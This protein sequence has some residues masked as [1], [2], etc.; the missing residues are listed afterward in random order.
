M[1]QRTSVSRLVASPTT[2]GKLA[3]PSRPTLSKTSTAAKRVSINPNPVTIPAT[4]DQTPIHTTTTTTST[5]AATTV[6]GTIPVA[7]TADPK[8][9]KNVIVSVASPVATEHSYANNDKGNPQNATG[10]TDS[11]TDTSSS[12]SSESSSSEDSDT[13]DL[14]H[15]L[16]AAAMAASQLSGTAGKKKKGRPRKSTPQHH[17]TT[18]PVASTPKSASSSAET[19]GDSKNRKRGRGCGSCPGC[20]RDDCGKCQYC[21]DKP[22]FG[23]PGR[24]KQRCSL[25]VCSNFVS[26]RAQ[27]PS[28]GCL[29]P[30]VLQV[31]APGV[32]NS[33]HTPEAAMLA[34][35]GA[36]I[37]AAS[38]HALA[39]P[40]RPVK[41]IKQSA[42]T[43][44]APPP[45]PAPAPS[46]VKKQ[47]KTV[48]TQPPLPSS[49][50]AVTPTPPSA[51]QPKS[52]QVER[53]VSLCI[54]TS[55]CLLEN[56]RSSQV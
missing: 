56:F 33:T 52:S 20:L 5:T 30:S 39:T 45:P 12:T 7:D 51:P 53:C 54:L 4:A 50:S 24:K 47:T 28:G 15:V 38:V 41:E 29:N 42:I 22:K 32:K 27:K 17:S 8:K 2:V 43:P 14:Q 37:A 35:T 40:T 18:S 36:Q 9:V 49:S 3:S 31:A 55:L 26:H 19:N 44:S 10:K 11:S 34:S 1:S 46:P 25:R 6:K 48:A 16:N 23:G 21:V 13:E